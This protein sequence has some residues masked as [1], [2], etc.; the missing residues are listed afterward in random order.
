MIIVRTL[1]SLIIGEKYQFVLR[2]NPN[3][4]ETPTLKT[5]QYPHDESSAI[6]MDTLA[7][8]GVARHG[9]GGHHMY[10]GGHC[11]CDARITTRISGVP[12]TE[13]ENCLA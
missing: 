9:G 11:S 7:G 4:C 6:I 10:T 3:N 8:A 2:M 13:Y 1:E 5:P 12:A